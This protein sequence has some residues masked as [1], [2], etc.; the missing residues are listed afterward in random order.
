MKRK[1]FLSFVEE[2][3]KI[4]NLFRGQ[5]KNENS[6]LEF[7]DFSI[8][9]PY[10]SEN[11]EYIKQQIRRK[12]DMV[13]VTVCLFGRNTYKSPWVD[14]EIEASARKGKGLV[15]VRIRSNNFDIIPPALTNNEGIIVSWNHKEID[16]SIRR[17]AR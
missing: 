4:V 12:L 11:E 1:I 14:W 5:A 7:Y 17:A 2:D 15:G 9:D 16:R 6:D 3:I 8:K 13:S 10:N